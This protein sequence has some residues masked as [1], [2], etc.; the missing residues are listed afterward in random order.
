MNKIY[1]FEEAICWVMKG[2]YARRQI[3]ADIPDYTQSTPPLAINR[4]WHIW[5]DMDNDGIYAGWG[6]SI[7][8]DVEPGN[9]IRDGCGYEPTDEDRIAQDWELYD[10]GR[11]M[12]NV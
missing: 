11:I 7:G 2:G 9:P 6:G 10:S 1:R 3:W 5:R 12:K 8:L 4:R